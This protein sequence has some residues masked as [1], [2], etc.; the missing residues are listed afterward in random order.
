[1]FEL[2]K[3]ST[4][5]VRVPAPLKGY[6]GGTKQLVPMIFLFYKKSFKKEFQKKDPFEALS[7]ISFDLVLTFLN[8]IR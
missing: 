1:M 4:F 3:G 6:K 5:I 2:G 8:S 7:I